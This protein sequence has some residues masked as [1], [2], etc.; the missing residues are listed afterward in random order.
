MFRLL[1]ACAL[2]VLCHAANISPVQKVVQMID[3]MSVK[4]QAD[5]DSMGKEFENHAKYCDAT[6]TSLS[7]GVTSSNEQIEALSATVED[8]TS[9][10][11]QL[12]SKI[13]DLS[14]KISDAE[15]E[16]AKAEALREM[17]HADFIASEGTMLETID[18]LSGAT[19]TLKK[20]LGFTQLSPDTKVRLN[21]LIG[22]L[23]EIVDADFVSFAERDQVR[24]FLQEKDDAADSLTLAQT[25]ESTPP[26]IIA[27]LEKM[28]EKAEASLSDARQTESKDAHSAA[29]MQQATQSE[30]QS[31]KEQLSEA[32]KL[33][34]F[35]VERKA[36]AS[37]DRAVEEKGLAQD[38]KTLTDTKHDCQ[39][40]AT[41]FESEARDGQ[42]EL[43]A[44]GKAKAI[45]IKKFSALMQVGTSVK[46][47]ADDGDDV[48]EDGR[49]QALRHVEEVG[50]TLHSTALV[51][52]AYRASANPFV[53]VKSVLEAMIEKL[54]QEAAE[55]AS[56][57]AF[58]DE[59][60]GKST[61]SQAQK[62]ASLAKTQARLDKTD[63]SIA[64]LMELVA[65]LSKE[66][67]AIDTSSAD[68][69]EVRNAEKASFK[70]T[71]K[72]FSES[73]QACAAA[74]S[75]LREYYEGASLMQLRTAAGASAGASVSGDGSGILG[76]LEVAE[77]DFARL[78]SEARAAEDAAA[79][80]F[81]KLR[82]DSRLDRATKEA[83]IKG[84]E[85]EI[86]SLRTA[87]ADYGEDKDSVSAE[88]TAVMSYLSKLQPQCETKAP[89]YAEVKA[90][91]EAEI[92]GLKEGLDMLAGD[93]I[94]LVQTSR[95]LR[96]SRRA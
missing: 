71:E 9:Q 80:A 1:V 86:K 62:E 91:R 73:E 96:K 55:E 31:F 18:T 53:K 23:G 77:A 69:A 46:A 37:K 94:A 20:T 66:I 7:Y 6:A 54:L 67:S 88:L 68:A 57:K 75:V 30:I 12:E 56:Q 74:I 40:R 89:S 83:D 58:C 3:D 60:I 11:Y 15:A 29:L 33:K 2:L 47:T 43:A 49:A 36:G 42:A 72:D 4:V 63:S 17:E 27:T 92:Q 32:T 10:I 39:D 81:L 14:S 51:A 48:S 76:L 26:A 22:G 45:L 82:E 70:V 78:L 52:L 19:E 50:R 90:Q 85:S 59:E 28:T 65:T 21:T 64:K 8:G 41:Q 35:N 34:Q 95:N 16:L 38:S 5:L 25:S 93:D 13:E 87:R 44:L 79:S 61:K 84:K 24:S